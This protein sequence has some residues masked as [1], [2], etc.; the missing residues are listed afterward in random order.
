MGAR[1]E[2]QGDGGKSFLDN[3]RIRYDDFQFQNGPPLPPKTIDSPF[4]LRRSSIDEKQLFSSGCAEIYSNFRW[5]VTIKWKSSPEGALTIQT[6]VDRPSTVG[7]H[8]FVLA[9]PVAA[10]CNHTT[11]SMTS[12]CEVTGIKGQR[13]THKGFQQKCT[14]AANGATCQCAPTLGPTR[15]IPRRGREMLR[16]FATAQVSHLAVRCRSP[17]NR[18]P[19]RITRH[20]GSNSRFLPVGRVVC[21]SDRIRE[22]RAKGHRS[23][24]SSRFTIASRGMQWNKKKAHSSSYFFRHF[25]ACASIVAMKNVQQMRLTE[26]WKRSVLWVRPGGGHQ[27]GVFLAR[28]TDESEWE[29]VEDGQKK[30]HNSEVESQPVNK[31]ESGGW[32]GVFFVRMPKSSAPLWPHRRNIS[33]KGG[34]IEYTVMQLLRSYFDG[35]FQIIM[36]LLLVWMCSHLSFET[37]IRSRR[38]SATLPAVQTCRQ[39]NSTEEERRIESGP[40]KEEA[41]ANKTPENLLRFPLAK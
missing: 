35:F 39:K 22:Y 26:R 14:T 12:G 1:D 31:G 7:L 16:D 10:S 6:K 34:G 2:E 19:G 13:Q 40:R 5:I 20:S 21:L 41:E 30:S 3:A 4:A 24:I 33:V 28:D 29:T 23:R 9:P 25:S 17:I 11:P 38:R 37:V 18:S 27:T 15:Q 32:S 8:I 36:F